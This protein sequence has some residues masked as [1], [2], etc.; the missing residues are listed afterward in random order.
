MKHY[1][2]K[3]SKK[4]GLPPGTPLH[5][6][7]PSTETPHITHILYDEDSVKKEEPHAISPTKPTE[8]K[9]HWLDVRCPHDIELMKSIGRTFTL[10]SLVIEDILNTAQHPKIEEHDHHFFII[11]KAIDFSENTLHFEHICIFFR[12]HHLLSFQ[13]KST[14]TFTIIK[15]RIIEKKGKIREKKTDYLLYTLIDYVIDTYFETLQK[16]D[17]HISM[18]TTEVDTSPRPDTLKRIQTL[19]KDILILKRQFWYTRDIVQ[20]LKKTES[21]LIAPKTHKYLQDLHDHISHIIDISESFR[22]ELIDL[23]ERHLSNINLRSNEIMKMLTIV[24]AI[25]M[26]LTFLAGIYGMNF[27]VMPELNW[28]WSYPILLGLMA[29]IAL[30]LMTLFKKKHWLD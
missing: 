18:F 23:S 11:I 10:H 1:L 9:I 20:S 12:E 30:F 28:P 6:G 3:L 13:E 8:K 19:K 24:A 26:P 22:E 17:T 7:T 21:S 4:K 2:S 29:A 5:I 25:F 16:I 14:D 27:R 15:D